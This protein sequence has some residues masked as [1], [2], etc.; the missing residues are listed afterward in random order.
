MSLA[1]VL[2][3]F[4]EQLAHI[5]FHKLKEPF[6]R[7]VESIFSR[8]DELNDT[9]SDMG[10]GIWFDGVDKRLI[11]AHSKKVVLV[12]GEEKSLLTKTPLLSYRGLLKKRKNVQ[13]NASNRNGANSNNT[14]STGTISHQSNS[15]LR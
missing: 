9:L 11:E 12:K 7:S 4:C 1:S 10:D 3:F 8:S 6:T 14:E 13:V 2:D 15:T 5:L